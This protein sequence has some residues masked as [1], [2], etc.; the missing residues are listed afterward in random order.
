[1]AAEKFIENAHLFLGIT[2]EE[3]RRRVNAGE[4]DLEIL[5]NQIDHNSQEMRLEALCEKWLDMR[6]LEQIDKFSAEE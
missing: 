4:I 2:R 3:F 5:K 6:S 1:M